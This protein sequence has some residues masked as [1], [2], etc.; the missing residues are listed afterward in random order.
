VTWHIAAAL[1]LRAINRFD[2][3]AKREVVDEAF[4]DS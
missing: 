3:T 4:R 1:F 2:H